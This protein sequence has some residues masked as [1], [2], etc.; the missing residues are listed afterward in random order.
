MA[1]S[2]TIRVISESSKVKNDEK[3]LITT[4]IQPPVFTLEDTV[5]EHFFHFYQYLNALYK[6]IKAT[7]LAKDSVRFLLESQHAV[8]RGLWRT[9]E[10]I[11]AR[12]FGNIFDAFFVDTRQ[13]SKLVKKLLD[14]SLTLIVERETPYIKPEDIPL[15][16][17]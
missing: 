14:G 6:R 1:T 11:I 16:W 3:L 17:N 5:E 7:C 4:K 13:E 9:V 12:Y 10:N 15:G 2:L 8:E